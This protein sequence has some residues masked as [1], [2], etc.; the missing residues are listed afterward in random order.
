M[1]HVYDRSFNMKLTISNDFDDFQNRAPINDA[2]L[3][4]MPIVHLISNQNSFDSAHFVVVEMFLPFLIFNVILKI[5]HVQTKNFG[6]AVRD[7]EEN[8]VAHDYLYD[9]KV[10]F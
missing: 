6:V 3:L 2:P 7:L 4:N 1:N 10:L 9:G 5:G 8:I